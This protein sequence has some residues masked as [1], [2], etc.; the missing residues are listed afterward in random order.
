MRFRRNVAFKSYSMGF[1]FRSIIVSKLL[2]LQIANK[3]ALVLLYRYKYCMQ[4]RPS[5]GQ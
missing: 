3:S 4:C 2:G 1:A 5:T